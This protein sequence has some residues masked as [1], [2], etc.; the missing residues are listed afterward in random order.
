MKEPIPKARKHFYSFGP[1]RLYVAERELFR[2]A[3]PVALPPKALDTLFVLVSRHG[4]VVDKDELM[5]S[6]WPDTF[7]EE[8]N[9]SKQISELRRV[10]GH[11]PDG[12]P[13]IE[14]IARRGYR[15]AIPVTESW[16]E[17]SDSVKLAPA[18]PAVRRAL[19]LRA[20]VAAAVLLAAVA[21]WLPS[22][23]KQGYSS[24]PG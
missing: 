10:L 22:G 13:Y 3:E 18:P 8:V 21:T 1:F 6:L 23:E 4:H 9:L 24:E 2:E 19:P 14:T 17:E 5:K 20:M 15:F 11:R 12:R 16:E 7:V